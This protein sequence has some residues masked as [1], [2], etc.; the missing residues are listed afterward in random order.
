MEER[1]GAQRPDGERREEW[2]ARRETQTGQRQ[3]E[4]GRGRREVHTG[5]AHTR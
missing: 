4:R 2:T 1:G 5:G 3:R